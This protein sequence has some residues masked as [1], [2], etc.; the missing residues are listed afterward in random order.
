MVNVI[1]A[2]AALVIAA[3]YWFG[4]EAIPAMLFGDTLG[5]TAYP[6]LL[7]LLLIGVAGLLLAE[8][9][10]GR[11]W[12]PAR[13]RF[14]GFLRE[15]GLTFALAAGSI[16]AF[17]LLFRPLGYLL[18]TLIFLLVSMLLLYRGPRWI[19]VAVTLIFC[20]ASYFIFIRAFG[21]QLPRGV[22]SF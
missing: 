14:R 20:A 15:D 5:P 7:M 19:P 4:I 1:L 11:D 8:G 18:S 9:L 22:L 12:A 10:R 16:L 2:I 21:T 13:A 3:F 6:R 17:F